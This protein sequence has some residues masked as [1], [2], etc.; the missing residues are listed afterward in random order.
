MTAADIAD[1]NGYLSF[2]TRAA[3]LA[4]QTT[5]ADDILREAQAPDIGELLDRLAGMILAQHRKRDA[6][7][8]LPEVVA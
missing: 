8:A 6:V 5:S 1:L 7:A 3:A 4:G 2:L